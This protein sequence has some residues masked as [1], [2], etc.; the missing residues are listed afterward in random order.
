[1]NLVNLVDSG[2]EKLKQGILTLQSRLRGL[3]V[4]KSY[5]RYHGAATVIQHKYRAHNLSKPTK[6][7]DLD[8]RNNN[9]GLSPD[10]AQSLVELRE[11][12]S[13]NGCNVASSRILFFSTD[14]AGIK[15]SRNE[16]TKNLQQQHCCCEYSIVH[17]H[18]VS[19]SEIPS[20]LQKS[21]SD[22]GKHPK[23][24]IYKR[25]MLKLYHFGR[26]QKH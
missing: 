17:P 19:I 16:D 5:R 4:R 7:G 23:T 10:L 11:K 24:S 26:A 13:S 8:A 1:M 21:A 12:L 25:P 20:P 2:L 6:W 15:G 18:F 22:A 14:F 9:D 3:V